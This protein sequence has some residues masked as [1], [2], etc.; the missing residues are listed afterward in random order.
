LSQTGSSSQNLLD[1]LGALG[2][3]GE[4]FD[5]I[6][7]KS[8]SDKNDAK[9][10]SEQASRARAAQEKLTLA[11]R[12]AAE[13]AASASRAATDALESSQSQLDD[14]YSQLSALQYSTAV[15]EREYQASQ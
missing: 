8:R 15:L 9:S 6:L 14:L 4:Q 3:L 1:R 12:S 5:V 13:A 10:L 2:K 7:A 11:A